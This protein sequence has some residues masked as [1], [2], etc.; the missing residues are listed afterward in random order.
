MPH[1]YLHIPFCKQACH[2]CDFHFSTS[3]Q[4]RGEMTDAL[5]AELGM[6][7]NELPAVSLET[8]YFGGGTPSLLTGDEL[9][10]IFEA[11][12]ENFSLAPDAEITLEANPDDLTDAYLRTLRHTPVNRLSIGI[13]SFRD[14]D[15]QLMN[16]AHTAADAKRVVQRAQDAGITNL[17]VDLIYGIPGLSNAAWLRNLDEAFSLGMQ[18]LSC[19]NLT[20]EPKT[21]L[22]WQVAKGFV[23]APDDALCEQQFILL[24]ERAA[25][26]GFVHYEISNFSLPGWEA[27][28]NSSY[29]KNK[30]YLGL[31]PSAH[32]YNGNQRSHNIANN[33]EYL[34]RIAA[35]QTAAT[36]EE[37]SPNER[38][39]E[40]VLTRL[41]TSWGIEET[42][43]NSRFAEFAPN[44]HTEATPWL[45]SGDMRFENGKWFL[46]PAG[47]LLADRIAAA[48]FVV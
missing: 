1:L 22:A 18:H 19:Y 30:P 24:T 38:Y 29:W 5:I 2:Y 31:G 4:R 34:R 6:R 20:V 28:H 47:K 21:A 25:D 10:R 7:K 11:I 14:D 27:R 32:S 41:R 45:R 48:L 39:N 26:A 16:R 33:S 12:G 8:V 36:V 44:F 46:S 23:R 17:S 43:L 9:M 3:Q 35:G 37:L 15:L 13:Q 40:F 42:E